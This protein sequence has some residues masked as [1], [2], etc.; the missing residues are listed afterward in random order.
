[1]YKEYDTC[2]TGKEDSASYHDVNL[3]K[4]GKIVR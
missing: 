2:K 1:M 4:N 3:L